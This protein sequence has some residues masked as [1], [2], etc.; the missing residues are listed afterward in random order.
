MIQWVNRGIR[1]GIK[2]TVYPS[3]PETATGVTPGLP[4]G[5]GHR[6]EEI[7]A[8]VGCC[9]TGAIIGQDDQVSIDYRR[10]VHCY[11]CDRQVSETL[12]WSQDYEWAGANETG[13]PQRTFGKE[14]NRSIHI[15]VVDAG[16]CGA[17]LN[18]VKQLN[19]PYYNMH[20]LGFFLT[21]TPRHADILMVVGPV[22]DHMRVAL[23]KT[24][25]AMPHPKKVVAVGA[26]ALSG[27]VFGPSFV[28]EAGVAKILPVDV[29]VPGQPPPP[30]AILHGLLVAA[31][32]K[33][34]AVLVSPPTIPPIREE[35]LTSPRAQ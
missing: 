30:L 35:P 10:C 24:Y 27:S 17:C 34:P 20:R 6:S 18:E 29:E 5:G 26:C 3:N 7:Q 25:E 16:D 31:G 13:D 12:L 23:Q 4:L 33:S 1:T 11:R 22:T 8:L 28:S 21:P 2:T 19:N 32:R 14:F 15:L 9:P